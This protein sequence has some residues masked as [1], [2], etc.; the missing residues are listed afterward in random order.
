MVAANEAL[1]TDI[2]LITSVWTDPLNTF[3]LAILSVWADPL[4]TLTLASLSA[5]PDP[6]KAFILEL[7]EAEGVLIKFA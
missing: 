4:N 2:L 1:I 7:N 6:D 5:W 3:T